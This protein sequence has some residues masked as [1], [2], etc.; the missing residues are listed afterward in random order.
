MGL[1]GS[2]SVG[3][4][5]RWWFISILCGGNEASK[6]PPDK[7]DDD[8]TPARGSNLS[9]MG[10]IDPRRKDGSQRGASTLGKG[11]VPLEGVRDRY[12]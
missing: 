5:N 1:R 2:T 9:K 8:E 7:G 4:V 10:K 11:V 6:D 3:V 12:F